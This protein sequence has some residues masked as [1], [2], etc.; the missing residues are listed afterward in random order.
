MREMGKSS[1]FLTDSRIHLDVQISAG[2]YIYFLHK[3]A[4][5][6]LIVSQEPM[7]RQ[8]QKLQLPNLVVLFAQHYTYIEYDHGIVNKQI[9]VTLSELNWSK[10]VIYINTPRIIHGRKYNSTLSFE[11]ASTQ[12]KINSNIHHS[13]HLVTLNVTM[14]PFLIIL[15]NQ[16]VDIVSLCKITCHL[17]D[18]GQCP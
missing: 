16:W 2:Q 12:V 4:F 14:S 11:S 15:Q 5:S 17:L 10:E 13:M 9:Y 1:L 7:H 3:W 8:K 18:I 6:S